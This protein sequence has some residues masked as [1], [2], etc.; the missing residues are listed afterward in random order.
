MNACQNSKVKTISF[1]SAAEVV[2]AAA[3]VVVNV[4]VA[5]AA[6]IEDIMAVVVIVVAAAEV[7]M[8]VALHL[9]IIGADLVGIIDHAVVLIHLVSIFEKC[10]TF[11]LVLSK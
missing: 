10:I 11:I 7:V 6:A 8:A 1:I 2:N 3:A 9:L 4:G 5:I